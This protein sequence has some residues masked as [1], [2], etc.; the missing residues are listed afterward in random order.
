M[1]NKL[2]L[3]VFLVLFSLPLIFSQF[4]TVDAACRISGY[5]LNSTGALTISSDYQAYC[6]NAGNTQ[7]IYNSTGG[8]FSWGGPSDTCAAYCGN[9][10]INATNVSL[11]I[12]GRANAGYPLNAGNVPGWSNTT[13]KA[14][15]NT[16]MYEPAETGCVGAL[17]TY[18]CGD[19][20]VEDCTFNG[21]LDCTGTA[22]FGIGAAG[23]VT[24]ECLNY[25]LSGA[26]AETIFTVLSNNVTIQNCVINDVSTGIATGS[27]YTVSDSNIFTGTSSAAI[28]G[29]GANYLISTGDTINCLETASAYG[30]LSDPRVGTNDGLRVIGTSID[31]CLV[32]VS[33]IAGSDLYVYQSTFGDNISTIAINGLSATNYNISDNDFTAVYRGIYLSRGSGIIER[34]V[35]TSDNGLNGYAITLEDGINTVVWNNSLTGF[36]DGIITDGET[37]IQISK[38]YINQNGATLPYGITVDATTGDVINNVIISSSIIDDSRAF[39]CGT[40]SIINYSGNNATNQDGGIYADA[41][42]ISGGPNRIISSRDFVISSGGLG[43]IDLFDL[44]TSETTVDLYA[45]DIDLKDSSLGGASLPA[46]MSTIGIYY[47]MTANSPFALA[48]INMSY[49]STY[50]ADENT[51]R[52]WKYNGTWTNL[53]SSGVN[54]GSNFVYSGDVSSFSLFAPLGVRVI[55]GNVDDTTCT[56]LR[57]ILILMAI[58]IMALSVWFAWGSYKSFENGNL[59]NNELLGKLFAA[60]IGVIVGVVLLI[61]TADILAGICLI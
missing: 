27:D 25:E 23:P 43:P 41:C 42:A 5:T 44:T 56:I 57:L 1:K 24:V 21:N 37:N 15:G 60:F 28:A 36:F 53:S 38:N 13:T 50:P 20:I 32:G 16:T 52:L 18:V 59:D 39:D 30:I 14:Y 45:I 2:Y 4:S 7:H 11:N 6:E 58:A 54:T 3:I 49:T 34:N 22:G 61:A 35:L 26:G 10:Y 46:N 12:S 48:N 9:V 8:L 19:L 31:D 33:H 17:A 40:I 29:S 51:L 47:N 55:S